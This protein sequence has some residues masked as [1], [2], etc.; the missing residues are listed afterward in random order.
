MRDNTRPVHLVANRRQ[1]SCQVKTGALTGAQHD[2]ACPRTDLR[3][4]RQELRR[5]RVV[6][7]GGGSSVDAV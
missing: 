7:L 1:V 3:G 2:S 5:W 6:Q 4:R